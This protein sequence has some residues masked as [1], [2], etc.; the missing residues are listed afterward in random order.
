MDINA[1]N[2]DGDTPLHLAIAG[3]NQEVVKYLL[4]N[5]ANNLIKNN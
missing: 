4:E 5:G 1:I 3:K 2:K